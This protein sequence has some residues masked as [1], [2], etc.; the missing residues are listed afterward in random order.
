VFHYCVFFPFILAFVHPGQLR[1]LLIWNFEGKRPGDLELPAPAVPENFTP[2]HQMHI[3]QQRGWSSTRLPFSP[4]LQNRNPDLT[5]SRG[6]TVFS[7]VFESF[8]LRRGKKIQ[9]DTKQFT[10]GSRSPQLGPV[11]GWVHTPFYIM[12]AARSS[13]KIL[14]HVARFVSAAR[15][16]DERLTTIDV[17]GEQYWAPTGEPAFPDRW[18]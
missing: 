9:T 7:S 16:R 2:L 11:N 17:M 6:R 14:S 5:K 12:K 18:A 4:R 10:R 3:S 8:A 15:S 13:L 1:L